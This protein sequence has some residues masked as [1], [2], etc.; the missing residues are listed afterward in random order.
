MYKVLVPVD[1]SMN[2][3]AGVRHALGLG[4]ARSDAEILLVNVQPALHRYV[5]RF[6]SRRTAWDARVQRARGALEEAR[7]LVDAAGLRSRAIVLRGDAAGA[8]A[9]LA[10]EEQV[11]QIVVGTS[12]ATP[13]Q[14]LFTGSISNRLV[15]LVSVPVAVIGGSRPGALAR[16]GIPAGLGLGLAALLLGE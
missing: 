4:A 5:S 11:D 8:I 2:A 7:K 12:R 1:G 15:E 14:R 13:L 10:A 16:Y 3:L 9:Q 6:V